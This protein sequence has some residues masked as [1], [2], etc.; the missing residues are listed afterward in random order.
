MAVTNRLLSKMKVILEEEA[1]LG[2]I[3]EEERRSVVDTLKKEADA[4][5][6]TATE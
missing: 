3:T 1:R 5:K 6:T 4:K 2:F